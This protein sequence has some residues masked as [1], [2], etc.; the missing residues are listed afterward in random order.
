V[1]LIKISRIESIILNLED[2]YTLREF[3]D[4]DPFRVL[5]RTILS[6]RTRDENTDAASAMLF[7]KYSTPEEIANAPTEEVEK[8][9][10]KSGFYHVKASRVREVSRII[11]E[12]YNDTVPEDMAELLSLP[13]VGR[14]TANC[15]MVYGFHKDAIPVDV[16]VH[17]I[18]NRIGLVTTGTPDET[19]EKLMKIVPKKFWLPLNDLFVQFGQTI[20]KPIG[21]KHEICPIA[22][23]CDYYKNM[24]NN[25]TGA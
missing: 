25:E 22:E 12:D 24:E 2:I 7:S 16:H 10:K 3:E 23:Y 11:H 5:I 17:R 6:Q 1:E 13:G 19:E 4:S 20:C 18:S 8:L 14:K 21:P 9:I 15:V